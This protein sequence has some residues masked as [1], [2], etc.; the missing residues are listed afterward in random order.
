M[1]VALRGYLQY[2]MNIY[3]SHVASLSQKEGI[4]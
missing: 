2:I 1:Y 3:T 4:H